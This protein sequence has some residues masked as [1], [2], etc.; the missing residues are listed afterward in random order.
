MSTLSRG[1]MGFFDRPIEARI[2]TRSRWSAGTSGPFAEVA[3]DSYI[4]QPH[5]TATS[6]PATSPGPNAYRHAPSSKARSAASTAPEPSRSAAQLAPQ[7][8]HVAVQNGPSA[9][10]LEV[11]SIGMKGRQHAAE[12]CPDRF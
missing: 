8:H 5:P 11:R 1:S 9:R 2:F 10:C 12:T 3:P 7:S 6:K 4:Q